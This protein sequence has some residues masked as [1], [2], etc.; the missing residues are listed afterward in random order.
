MNPSYILHAIAIAWEFLAL[1]AKYINLELLSDDDGFSYLE[2]VS[3]GASHLD[4]L[5]VSQDKI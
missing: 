1:K 3:V 2:F 5:V 4:T